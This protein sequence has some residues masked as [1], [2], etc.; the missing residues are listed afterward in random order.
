MMKS[1]LMNLKLS[2]K[3]MIAPAAV[4]VFLLI[5]GIVSYLSLS[6]QKS[7]IE[8]IFGTRFKSYQVSA[9]LSKDV[10]S[11]HANLYKVL[12]WATANYDVKKIDTLGSEQLKTLGDAVK[13]VEQVLKTARLT[14]DEGA[15]YRTTLAAL[16]AYQKDASEA[17]DLAS[18][19]VNYA[20]TFMEKAED[21]FQILYK[22]LN[23]LLELETALGKVTYDG[24]L[25]NFNA[26]LQISVFVLVIAIVVSILLSLLIARIIT[27]PV[28]KAIEVIQKIA[29]GDL[30]QTIELN[31][32]DEIGML[33]QAVD[34]MRQK[35]GEAV[36]VAVETSQAL[37]DAASEQAASIE[38]TS[39]SLE[40][41]ASMIKSNADS[42]ETANALMTGAKE[43]IEKADGSMNQLTV[44]MKE[45]ASASEQT[46]KIVKTIDEIAFQTN[47]LALNAA[48]EAARAGEAGAGFAVV[49][50]EVRN[51]A[52][53]AAE[54]AKNTASLMGD[55]VGK[56]HGGEKLVAATSNDFFAMKE[57]SNKVVDLVSGIASASREQSIGIEQ[58]NQ[59]ILHLNQA[60]QQNASSSEEL[61]AIMSIFITDSA[62]IHEK[63]EYLPI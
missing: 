4:I 44:S 17:I 18:S 58:I 43:T 53:R 20:T 62:R 60:T 42:T 46:Q 16:T 30:T 48:V 33:A 3:I 5:S 1:L 21:K 37:S 40:E 10:T 51:L 23:N 38:E 61:A 49:A 26:S 41:M 57:N 59:A 47:L 36:G 45:I 19:D 7:A 13:E 56:V 9:R 39:S 22:Q 6:Q 35:M 55:I 14:K 27:A 52:L 28:D 50:G 31:S 29:D 25:K 34:T 63:R 2:K 32:H 54:A 8:E 24:S 11:V 12:S 15:A